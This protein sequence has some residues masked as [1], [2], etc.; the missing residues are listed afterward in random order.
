MT[1]TEADFVKQTV[2]RFYGNDAIV[3][4]YGP[5]PKRLELHV[6]TDV[7]PG[8]ERHECLGLLMCDLMRDYV[9]LEVTKRG[10][11]ARGS[12][13]IAYRQGEVI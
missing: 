3:R 4:N 6:E 8:M 10:R 9:G 12:A 11:P 5:D 13:K 1:P 7:E 2:R